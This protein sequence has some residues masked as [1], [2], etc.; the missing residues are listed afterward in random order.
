MNND[1]FNNGLKKYDEIFGASASDNVTQLGDLGKYVAEFSYGDVY[2]RPG[3]ALREREIAAIAM[4]ASRSGVDAMLR[5]HIKGGFNVGLTY[6]E[7]EEVIIQTSLF[8]GFATAIQAL[9]ILQEF[10]EDH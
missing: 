6:K 7:I 8:S 1:R 2:S 9:Q 4:L 5:I 10:K 3:L